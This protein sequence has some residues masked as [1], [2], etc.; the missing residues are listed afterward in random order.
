[1]RQLLHCWMLVPR[2]AHLGLPR[3]SE[4]SRINHLLTYV[5]GRDWQ[6]QGTAMSLAA[7]ADDVKMIETLLLR[8]F[9]IDER[10]EV[11]VGVW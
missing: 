4:C 3:Y 7:A 9:A 10:A 8:G 2:L 5:L 6:L 1:M 11:C